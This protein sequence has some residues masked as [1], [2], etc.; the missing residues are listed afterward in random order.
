MVVTKAQWSA[1]TAAVPAHTPLARLH[2]GAAH[3]FRWSHA[4]TGINAAENYVHHPLPQ[5]K[6]LCYLIC[7]LK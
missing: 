4:H 6:L 7:Q 3:S 5:E 1:H 2:L